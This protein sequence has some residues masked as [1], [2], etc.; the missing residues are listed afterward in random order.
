MTCFGEREGKYFAYFEEVLLF[1]SVFTH[2][3]NFKFRFVL[4]M[5]YFMSN[6][7]NRCVL[8]KLFS[9]AITLVTTRGIRVSSC[10]PGIGES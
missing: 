9:H 4:N 5:L 3:Y 2:F 10:K 7:C 6:Y 1:T 8:N